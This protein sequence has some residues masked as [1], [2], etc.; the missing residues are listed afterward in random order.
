MQRQQ[1]ASTEASIC[2]HETGREWL[3]QGTYCPGSR[4]CRDP[5]G[6]QL[7]P[8]TEG[9]FVDLLVTDADG[10]EIYLTPSV[11]GRAK[12]ALWEHVKDG[13]DD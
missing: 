5:W 4:G 6:L 9:C 2:D 3:V 13:A 7:E 12:E 11:E 10:E 1:T 8:D